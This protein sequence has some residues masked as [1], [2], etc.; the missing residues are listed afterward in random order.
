MIRSQIQNRFYMTNCIQSTSYFI[1]ITNRT[2]QKYMF[3]ISRNRYRNNNKPNS[4]RCG[5]MRLDV[6]KDNSIDIIPLWNFHNEAYR[7]YTIFC[8]ST[9]VRC[10]SRVI[11]GRKA[12]AAMTGSRLISGSSCERW[13][14]VEISVGL[15]MRVGDHSASKFTVGTLLGNSKEIGRNMYLIILFLFSIS[16]PSV[17]SPHTRISPSHPFRRVNTSS[18]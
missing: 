7:E 4:A 8:S 5:S 1:E 12:A 13:T 16:S 6:N 11:C 18:A 3:S 14:M 9:N 10:E 2:E 15:W 17:G